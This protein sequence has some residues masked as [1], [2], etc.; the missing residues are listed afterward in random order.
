MTE[1]KCPTDE[2]ICDLMLYLDWPP[3]AN[4]IWRNVGGKVLVSKDYKAWKKR[5]MDYMI[6]EAF[7]M[8]DASWLE[9]RLAVQITLT[10]STNHKWDI[11]NRV[12]PI[13]DALESIIK[14]DDQIDEL[15]VIRTEKGPQK[16]CQVLLFPARSIQALPTHSSGTQDGIQTEPLRRRS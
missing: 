10:P 8:R 4:K 1:T 12:K 5:T 11:D 6:S 2:E 16:V 9:G 7:R 14:N 13:F 3:S 15:T